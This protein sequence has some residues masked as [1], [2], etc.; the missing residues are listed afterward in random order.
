MNILFDNASLVYNLDLTTAQH[1]TILVQSN[2]IQHCVMK[3]VMISW[4]NFV[5]L[6]I[7][8]DNWANHPQILDIQNLF[9]NLILFDLDLNHIIQNALGLN[10]GRSIVLNRLGNE[11]PANRLH[12]VDCRKWMIGRQLHDTS[13]GQSYIFHFSSWV[14]KIL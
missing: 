3:R 6:V 5:R 8:L 9:Q 13:N 4:L 12:S 14:C 10:I 1:L 2:L 11:A 7:H